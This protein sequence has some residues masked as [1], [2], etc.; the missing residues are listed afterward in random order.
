MWD[1]TAKSNLTGRM[2]LV[3]FP[4]SILSLLFGI[5]LPLIGKEDCDANYWGKNEEANHSANRV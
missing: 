2:I 1:T 5:L 4:L 3:R